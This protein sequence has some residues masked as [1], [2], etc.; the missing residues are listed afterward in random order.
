MTVA[1]RLYLLV[2]SAVLGLIALAA[3]GYMQINKVFDST[4]YA[5]V[6]TVP[7]LL[8]LAEVRAPFNNLRAQSLT[9]V[10]TESDSEMR[11]I[12]RG[13]DATVEKLNLAIKAYDSTG[14]LGASCLSDAKEKGMFEEVKAALQDYNQTRVKMIELS[15]AHK[16]AE[17]LAVI[18]NQLMPAAAKVV[19][20]INAENDYNA[21]LGRKGAEEATSAKS[22]A[23]MLSL[24]IALVVM[25]VVG[26]MGFFI[27][28]NLMRALGGEPAQAAEVANKIAVG[29]LSSRFD[30]KAGDTSSLMVAMK[31]MNEILESVMVDTDK[32]VKAAA[33][34]DL[35]TR[36][37][38]SK[39]QGDF[40]KL[41]Q[42]VND[43]I[44]NIAE[45]MKV[46]SNYIDQIAKGVIPNQITTDYKG[47]YLVIRNNLNTLVKM[48]S[49]LLNETNI[50]IQGAA[51]GDLD[52]RANA[53]MFQ[54]GWNQLVVGVNDTVKNIAEPFKVTSN[55]IDQITKGVIPATITT[56]Y[57]GEYLVVRNN[58]NGLIK[59]MGDLLNETDILI[60]GAAVGELD[61]RANAEMFQGGWKQLVVGV[62]DT[63]RNIAEPMKVTSDYVDQIAKG[64]IPSQITTDYKGEYL[65]IRN[66]LN[67]LVKMMGDLLGETDMLIQGA[68]AGELDKRAN[69][70][71][72]QGG[73]NQLVVGVN[74]IVETVDIAFKDTV[75]VA[76]ALAKGDLSQK[77]T[78]EYRG[79]FN[80]VKQSVNGTADSLIQIVGEIRDIVA[81]ANRGD[82]NS[83]MNL[84]GKVGFGK[85]L[86]ELL[87]QLSDTVDIAFK[88][89]IHVASALERGDLTQVVTREYQ[90]AFDQVKQSLNNTVA[91]LSQVIGEVNAAAT[92][93]ASASEEVSST[94]QSMSQATNEQAAS[95]E[96]TSASVE[97]MGASIN[98]NSENAKVTD[99]MA[100]Q[101]AKQATE[102]G[103]AVKETVTAMKQI[104]GK[105]GIIDDIAYQT[106]LLA[107]NAA[108]EAA[109]AGEHGKG[110]AVVA[111]EVR[112]LAERSQV[113]AQEIG[114][115]AGG[116]VDKAEEAGKLLDEIV[117]A[118]NKTSDLVQE[119]T[120]ASEE[121]SSG[122]TQINTAMNQLNTITQQNA[123]S[124]EELAAT[125]EEM[126]GQAEQL[127]QLMSF[128][129]V[130]GGAAQTQL[131]SAAHT[132][133][134]KLVTKS[135]KTGA[136]LSASPAHDESE[137]VKF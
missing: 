11:E 119:I 89:T 60:Q 121:Q 27:I 74:Q 82:F 2:F 132:T 117:P 129:K 68:A 53:E 45:P 137:F 47:E 38:A 21:E 29:D 126:S 63:V 131:H 128:F 55:Y 64:I 66:N 32:L 14:C 19:A 40:R 78:R 71:Q 67:T 83:K 50:L 134:S 115:L 75:R 6:N 130:S 106:N 24:V 76:E 97:Q 125:A 48:M 120:A 49:D 113:A 114:E 88:D 92:N 107:L 84:D 69:A 59:M 35:N 16:N 57:K 46:T 73:W 95:V 81:A 30:I 136:K 56:E 8:A 111:A 26:V 118:I 15:R 122:A 37:D 135:A 93:I 123:S 87:N 72:F 86:S 54:G 44:T 31:K 108:I 110:F 109:R 3:V 17:A 101:A 91:K 22:F 43:T 58:L 103:V 94:A 104:A 41:V 52:K 13:I 10:I 90:G 99:S 116:S 102:G 105:I 112:K 65:V 77:V 12:E 7:S 34:G 51:V 9:H 1:Q 124:T 4:N 33:V 61:K 98:Q 28:R 100:A 36:A 39:Y 96:E 80:V 133:V 25:S 5:N 85:E 127:Q 20:A 79:T 62:N 42:G 18:R 70:A 23:L